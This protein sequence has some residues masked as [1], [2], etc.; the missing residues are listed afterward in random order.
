MWWLHWESNSGFSACQ[1]DMMTTT[2]WNLKVQL[3]L[4][5]SLGG[6]YLSSYCTKQQ[7]DADQILTELLGLYTNDSL[8]IHWRYQL[9]NKNPCL[10]DVE[11]CHLY[12][13]LVVF[14]K[15]EP[16]QDI[17]QGFRA[18]T[19]KVFS[20]VLQ[21]RVLCFAFGIVPHRSRKLCCF[22]LSNPIPPTTAKEFASGFQR[23]ELPYQSNKS[24][25]KLGYCNDSDLKATLFERP[26]IGA[27]PVIST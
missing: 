7:K 16:G 4:S 23:V 11:E 8:K 1:A 6:M 12:K 13:I 5:G 3:R 14:Q 10:S 15:R 22:Q 26:V 25:V 24:V 21:D 9:I 2:P 20:Q 17:K 27:N 19:G 18:W